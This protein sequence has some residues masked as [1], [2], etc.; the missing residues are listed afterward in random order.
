MQMHTYVKETITI[1]GGGNDNA[2][3]EADERNKG[4]IFKNSA[5]FTKCISRINNTYI[6]NAKDID[7]VMPMHNLIEYSDNYSKQ[8]RGLL[9]YY[10]DDH[11]DNIVDS[12]SFKFKVKIKGKIPEAGNRKDIE[13]IVP[14]KCLSNFWRTLEM[15][16]TSSKINLILTWS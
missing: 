12:K 10:R 8:S 1:N 3:R 16:L 7:I 6:D 13:I 2:A 5:P 15:P 9:Q 14:L 11:N 4:I